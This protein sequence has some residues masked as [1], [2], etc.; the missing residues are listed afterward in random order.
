[1]NLFHMKVLLHFWAD[2]MFSFNSINSQE[3]FEINTDR[4]GTAAFLPLPP[5]HQHENFPPSLF[6]ASALPLP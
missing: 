5:S 4:E 3:S 2:F 1:M 6:R